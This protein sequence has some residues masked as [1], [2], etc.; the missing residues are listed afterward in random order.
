MHLRP[1]HEHAQAPV[2]HLGESLPIERA[3]YF[4]PR[5]FHVDDPRA[6]QPTQVPRHQRL[7]DAET[8]RELR[9]R[10]LSFV[11]EHVHDPQAVD[12]AERAIV[13]PKLS[14]G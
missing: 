4:A 6:A 13:A 7:A 2:I 8:S 14:Q 3:P 5:A 10:L 9:H 12:V 11:H 1:I